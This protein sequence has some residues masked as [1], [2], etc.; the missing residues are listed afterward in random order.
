M[1]EKRRR[2]LEA[3]QSDEHEESRKRSIRQAQ[4]RAVLKVLWD[5]LSASQ[6]N[7]IRN[8]VLKGQPPALQKRPALVERW[9]LEELGKRNIAAF[10]DPEFSYQLMREDRRGLRLTR[11]HTACLTG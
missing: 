4:D 6:K 7:E 8:H 3:R 5:E 1:R 10:V 11:L 2:E 9:C